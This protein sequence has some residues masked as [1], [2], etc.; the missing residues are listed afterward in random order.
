MTRFSFS[1]SSISPSLSKQRISVRADVLP[2]RDRV[3]EW[4]KKKK[5]GADRESHR[6]QE[7]VWWAE[8]HKVGAKLCPIAEQEHFNQRQTISPQKLACTFFPLSL[9]IFVMAQLVCSMTKTFS[10]IGVIAT[11]ARILS[12]H[13]LHHCECNPGSDMERKKF[14]SKNWST[15]VRF[16]ETLVSS[17]KFLLF[18][19]V[20]F[21]LFCRL[22]PHFLHLAASVK[23]SRV[24]KQCLLKT[25]TLAGVQTAKDWCRKSDI[26]TW[27][28]GF[29]VWSEDRKKRTA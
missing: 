4:H 24:L 13:F 19:K 9:Q 7:S 29:N 14:W 27:L 5:N 28:C 2:F 21:I 18:Q 6:G 26:P 3:T 15:F 8:W 12:A 22:N 17:P 25:T 20:A 23:L 11:S 10:S 1:S 16:W